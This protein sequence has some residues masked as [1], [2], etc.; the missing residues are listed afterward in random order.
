MKNLLL[1][2]LGAMVASVLCYVTGFLMV[3]IMSV[4]EDQG[5]GFGFKPWNLQGTVIGLVAWGAIVFYTLRRQRKSD[6]RRRPK[7][8]TPGMSAIGPITGVR[9]NLG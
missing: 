4:P 6:A 7:E 3:T 8:K 5:F 1:G 2:A 9:K